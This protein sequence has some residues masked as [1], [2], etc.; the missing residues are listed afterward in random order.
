[1]FKAN[2]AWYVESLNI[3]ST[4]GLIDFFN[5]LGDLPEWGDTH[6]RQEFSKVVFSFS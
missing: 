1:L 2:D 3:T 4:G 5:S 6:N